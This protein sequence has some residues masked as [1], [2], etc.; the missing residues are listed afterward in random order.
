MLII[1]LRFNLKIIIGYHN[2]EFRYSSSHKWTNDKNYDF[3]FKFKPLLCGFLPLNIF[4]L[5]YLKKKEFKFKP[6]LI[7]MILKLKFKIVVTNYDFK[8]KP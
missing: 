1:S 8:I 4:A 2:F 6:H 5:T 3:K 7:I